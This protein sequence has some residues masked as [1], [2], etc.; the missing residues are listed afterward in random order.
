MSHPFSPAD[1][2]FDG[3]GLDSR[4]IFWVRFRMGRKLG[5]PSVVIP[6]ADLNATSSELWRRIGNQGVVLT[7]A[8]KKLILGRVKP[9]RDSYSF[10]IISSLGWRGS[11]YVTPTH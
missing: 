11:S 5:S 4:R 6:A 2:R 7:T 9:F 8:D 1:I 3:F 10:H